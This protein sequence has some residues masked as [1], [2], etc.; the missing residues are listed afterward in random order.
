MTLE[1]NLMFPRGI[2]AGHGGQTPAAEQ[3]EGELNRDPR[4][5][6]TWSVLAATCSMA[7]QEPQPL[8]DLSVK[9]PS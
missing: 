4:R 1:K 9:L 8:E 2:G 7:H 5:T 6:K 3:G